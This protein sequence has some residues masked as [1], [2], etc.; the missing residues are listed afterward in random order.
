MQIDVYLP[1][2]EWPYAPLENHHRKLL[3]AARFWNSI[4]KFTQYFPRES[5]IVKHMISLPELGI[6]FWEKKKNIN[7]T[8]KRRG[9]KK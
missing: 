4:V 1:R 6:V 8:Q 2:C 9:D 3:S 5:K 7:Q